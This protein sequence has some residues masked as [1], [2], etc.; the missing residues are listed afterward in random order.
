MTL[1]TLFLDD[2]TR[3]IPPVVYFHEQTPERLASE[4]SQYIITGGWLS[5]DPR[6]Q[7]VPNG[8]HE[9]YVRLLT[10]ITQALTRPGGVDLPSSWISGFYGSG[11]SSFAK[12]LGLALDGVTLPDGR[13][14]ADHLI[15][16]DTSPQAHELRAAWDALTA[17]CPAPLAVVFDIGGRARDDE[18]VHAV[19]LRHLQA[20]LGYCP[21]PWVAEYELRFEQDGTWPDFL[22]AAA[23]VLDAPWDEV[24]HGSFPE[25]EFSRVLHHLR[26]DLYTDPLSWM[27][28]RSGNY[29]ATASASEVTANIA[30]MLDHRA[31]GRTLFFVIDEVSQYLHQDDGRMLKLQSFVSE[32]GQRLRGRV[33][34]LVTGQ[35][36]LEHAGDA[37]VLGKLQD[38]FPERLRVHLAATNIRDVVHRRLLHKSPAGEDRLRPLYRTHKSDLRLFGYASDTLTEDDFVEVYPLLPGHVDLLL[39][40]TSALRLRST[41]SQGDAQAIR[42]LLQ[43]LGELF[44]TQGLADLPVGHL[45]TLDQIYEIQASALDSDTQNTLATI[46]RH[47]ADHGL[48]LAARAAKAVALL[49]LL[50]E[51][52]PV[53]ADLVSRCLW[54]RLDRGDQTQAVAAALTALREANLLGYSERQGFKIQSS[55][56]E[57]WERERRTL[58]APA[59]VTSDLVQAALDYLVNLPEQPA[60]AGRRFPWA[61]FFSD[62]RSLDRALKRASDP[63]AVTVDLRWLRSAAERAPDAWIRLSGAGA[64]HEHRLYWVAGDTATADEVARDLAKTKA[65]VQRYKD[66]RQGLP[67]ERQRLLSDEEAREEELTRR[68]RDAVDAAFVAGAFYFRGR[69]LTPRDLGASFELALAAAGAHVIGDLFPHFEPFQV[70]P[71]S[72]AQLLTDGEIS[73]PAVVFTDRGLG[74]LELD[75]GAWVATCR[76]A[77]PQRV[78]ALVPAGHGVRGADLLAELGGPPWGYPQMVIKAVVAGLFRAQR[79]QIDPAG[80]GDRM[81]HLRDADAKQLFE[82]DRAFKDAIFRPAGEDPIGFRGLAKLAQFFSDAV[83]RSVPRDAAAL[84]DACGQHLPELAAR[85]R[86]VEAR[87]N[88]LRPSPATPHQLAALTRAIE[89]IVR[90]VRATDPAIRTAIGQLEDLTEGLN[91]L[92][93]TESELTDAA[94]ATLIAAADAAALAAQLDAAGL[95]DADTRALADPITAHLAGPRPWEAHIALA[96][97][98]DALRTTYTVARRGL[99][100]AQERAAEAARDRV[101]A[102]PGFTGLTADQSHHVL[103]PIAEAGVDTTAAATT[104]P[105]TALGAPF[106]AALAEA[107]EEAM[108]RLDHLL[109]KVARVTLRLKNRVVSSRAEL[110]QLV[111]QVT[112]QIGA[113]LDQGY[114]VR[115]TIDP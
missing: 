92:Q 31:P 101:R 15:A 104:P 76:G 103:R 97:P 3:D 93:R 9:Q 45:V 81:T 68:L 59:D 33:W 112:E 21:N 99:I 57:E 41:R 85:V 106:T 29:V 1:R 49:E 89:A 12:L 96:A 26:P 42:G 105:L 17:A 4:A 71:A 90:R 61:A 107:E 73:S 30:A 2:V 28:A 16:R 108:A 86:A 56:G 11:K 20:R 72:L 95:L 113:Q 23:Q 88:R 83:G 84:A 114:Q 47:C 91:T 53:T 50:S 35:E 78:L 109:V 39:Q 37:V 98:T 110:D 5:T 80:G 13:P 6:H 32:L 7:R 102:R 55:A 46:I 40:I 111:A 44:R 10:G 22:R 65:M 70:E 60:I 66:R 48:A 19:A 8:I 27:D 115:I 18:H 75:G 74:L 63:A 54:D 58:S 25:E 67:R 87:L 36:Q 77:V 64:T 51:T 69:P 34:L 100:E 38:R 79:I 14:L 82:R 24:K 52:T 62:Y 94:V 43:L